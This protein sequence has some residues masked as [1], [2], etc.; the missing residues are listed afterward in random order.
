MSSN[1]Y[2]ITYYL[3]YPGLGNE[4]NHDLRVLDAQVYASSSVG[5]VEQVPCITHLGYKQRTETPAIIHGNCL[6]GIYF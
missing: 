6:N 2:Y 4:P 3:G 5:A 1:P